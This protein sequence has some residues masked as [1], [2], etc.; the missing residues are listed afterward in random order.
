MYLLRL[1]K[2]KSEEDL[3]KIESNIAEYFGMSRMD[4]ISF[5]KQKL[6][7]QLLLSIF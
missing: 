4:W 1:N 3:V 2:I 6:I 7:A 5:R